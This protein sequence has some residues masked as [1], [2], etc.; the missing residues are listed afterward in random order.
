MR[1][2]GERTL[3]RLGRDDDA[4]E[5]LAFF[6][7]NRAHHK[8]WE[9]RMREAFFTL[10]AQ[11]GLIRR[12]RAEFEEGRSA[13]LLMFDRIHDDGRLIGRINFTEIVRG[14]F[15]ACMLGYAVDHEHEGR[16]YMYE[17]LR[18]AIGWVFTELRLHRVMANYR[19]ENERSG[20]LLERLGF[21]REGYAEAYLFIDGA[22]CDHVLTALTNPNPELVDVV[23]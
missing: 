5:L 17:G 12:R 20:R 7:R 21:Q 16:G 10:S 2:E 13:C 19:P 11:Q 1:I 23:R 15:Q 6:L 9:P 14:P 8:R 22:W 18:A 4:S 3:L